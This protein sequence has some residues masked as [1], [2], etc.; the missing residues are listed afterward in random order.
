MRLKFGQLVFTVV[1][2][3]FTVTSCTKIEKTTMGGDLI[4]AVDN[5]TT[6]DT[7]MEVVSNNYIPEDSTRLNASND[8]MVGG[9]SDDPLFGTTR[10]TMFFELKPPN[11]PFLFESHDSIMMFDSAVL[12]LKYQGYYGDSSYP[13]NFN[14]Y[15]V[16][17]TIKPDLFVK[18]NYTIESGLKPDYSIL[19]GQKT[20][21]ANRYKDTITLIRGTDT[22]RAKK[23]LN[24]LRIPLNK[25][26]AEKLFKVDTV[27]LY[28]NDSI[29]E[30]TLPGFALEAQGNPRALHYFNLS[31]GESKIEFYYRAKRGGTA[32]D[33]I[34]RDFVFNTLCGHAV[35]LKRDR[36]GA[37]INNFLV[38]NPTTGVPQV[39]FQG[40]PGSMV[41]VDIPGIK[42]LSN[43]VLHR[44]ELR[45]TELTENSNPQYSQLRAPTALYLDGEY[46]NDPGNFRGVPYDLNPFS[47]YYCYPGTGV[48]FSYFGG[49]QNT[50]T[51]DGK[52]LAQYTFNIT[53]YVQSII[54]RGEPS[55]KLRLSAPFYMYYKDCSNGLASYPSQVYPFQSGGVFL[56]EV[57]E[58]RLRAA[59]G[60]HPDPK[61]RMQVR[62]I[63]SKL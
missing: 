56:N 36:T 53:R 8:H 55:F 38:Q 54:T 57:G 14:L 51:I 20:M 35:D 46:E 12:V 29:F 58:F 62:V 39:Y 60:N 34:S 9:I 37:E 3:I 30:Q 10:S 28:K 2:S 61:L 6:F 7:I 16:K 11:Y 18:P 48:D 44:V 59:G 41:S 1:L 47:K 49:L 52:K 40:T 22:A 42:T 33:T 19:W 23:V 63:Y 24:Q 43:R 50:V 17:D 26:L 32:V 21:Q 13:V 4:P 5:V 31:G 27:N 15:Q 45:I 25:A